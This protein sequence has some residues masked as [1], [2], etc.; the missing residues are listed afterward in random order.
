MTRA[1]NGIVMQRTKTMTH[2]CLA[3]DRPPF[4]PT[5]RRWPWGSIAV[6]LVVVVL[7]L[8]GELWAA[9]EGPALEKSVGSEVATELNS[10]LAGVVAASVLIGPADQ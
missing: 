5:R 9:R 7:V 8:G 6:A 1:A 3:A 2:D 4:S 10:T